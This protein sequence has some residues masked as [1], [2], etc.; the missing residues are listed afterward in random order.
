[1]DFKTQLTGLNQFLSTILGEETRISGLL[2][3]LGFEQARIELLRD[4][5]MEPVVSQFVEVI[6]KRLTSD[7]GKDAWFQLLN[8]RFGLD[9]EPPEPLD[10]IAGR[11]GFSPEY[12]RQVYEEVLQKCRYK[13]TLEDF[14][15]NLRYIA[16]KQ[17]GKIAEPPRRDDVSA[18]LERLTNLHAAADLARMDYEARRAEILKEIQAELDALE[19]EYEPLIEAAGQNIAALEA[20]IKNDVLLH[21]ESVQG[22]TY[23]ALYVQGRVSWDNEGMSRYA[24]TH[25]DILQ[26]RKQGQP[27]VTLRTV[28]EKKK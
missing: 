22:G 6:H 9:G 11:L 20:E 28:E 18:K 19:A 27:T 16:I 17:L 3:S 15:K 10:A 24:E 26:F 4:Q 14:K 21:G 8:R 25:A 12:A 2:A 5:H 23:R 1:M 7:S 13:T